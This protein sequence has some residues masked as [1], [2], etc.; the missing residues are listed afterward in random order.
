[1]ALR[2]RRVQQSLGTREGFQGEIFQ[3]L[4][5]QLH[6]E[7]VLRVWISG[8]RLL[9]TLRNKCRMRKVSLGLVVPYADFCH[10]V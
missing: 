5:M 7:L 4:V 9:F 6:G 1:M 2:C 10:A 8:L 3:G